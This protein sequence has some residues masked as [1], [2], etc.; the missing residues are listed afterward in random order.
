VRNRSEFKELYQKHRELVIAV[1]DKVSA[2]LDARNEFKIEGTLDE[3]EIKREYTIVLES[4]KEVL[5]GQ[6]PFEEI[7]KE[8]FSL[9]SSEKNF[10]KETD[11]FMRSLDK[12]AR[13]LKT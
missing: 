10:E 12:R 3:D 4:I 13:D 8:K 5:G 7:L 9:S 6:G 11:F 1:M 2:S